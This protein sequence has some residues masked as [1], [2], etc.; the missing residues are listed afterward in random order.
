M[1]HWLSEENYDSEMNTQVL[2]YLDERRQTGYF[3]RIPG[4]K[5]YYEH[6]HADEPMGVIIISHGFT[7]SIRKYYESIY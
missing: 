5:I 2:P 7:E 3:E 4:E 1:I 6:Y